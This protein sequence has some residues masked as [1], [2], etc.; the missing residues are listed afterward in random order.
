M[1]I[2]KDGKDHFLNDTRYNDPK[3]ETICGRSSMCR[4]TNSASMRVRTQVRTRVPTARPGSLP[5]DTDRDRCNNCDAS[6]DVA[7]CKML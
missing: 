3:K 4:Y 2:K 5:G 1:T 7:K 6:Q